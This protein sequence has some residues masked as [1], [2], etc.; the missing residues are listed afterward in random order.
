VENIESIRSDAANRPDDQGRF[1][2][3]TFK[4]R[5][6][7]KNKRRFE[8][9]ESST[10]FTVSGTLYLT[11]DASALLG[12]PDVVMVTVEAAHIGSID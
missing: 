6:S 10:G 3:V 5:N 4:L 1:V 11:K 12:N 9:L 8:E 7:T 2:I